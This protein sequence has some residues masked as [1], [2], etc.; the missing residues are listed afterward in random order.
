[1]NKLFTKVAALTLGVAM[2]AGVGV[3][4]GSAKASEA[5]ADYVLA[6]SF[7]FE[8]AS[9]GTS[10][11][12]TATTAVTFLNTAAGSS[13]VA[14][15]SNVAKAYSAKGS[16]G[17]GVPDKV[18]KLGSGSSAGSLTFTLASTA[19]EVTKAV[20]TAYNW[21]K[22][23]VDITVNSVQRTKA[24]ATAASVDDYVFEF[25]ATREIAMSVPADRAFSITKIELYKTSGTPVTSYS[26]TDSVEHG[27]VSPSKVNEGATLT[28]TIKPDTG[29]TLPETVTVTMG[30]TAATHTYQNGVVTVQNVTG[31]VVI[32]G[33]C[34]EKQAPQPVDLPDGEYTASFPY[35]NPFP[36][37]IDV[38]DGQSAKVAALTS[39]ISAVSTYDDSHSEYVIAANQS[40]EI[41]NLTNGKI[42]KV[43]IHIYQYKN[44]NV[45]V[46]DAT[47]PVYTGDGT[48]AGNDAH[49]EVTTNALSKVKI[50]GNGGDNGSRTFKVFD[51]KVYI[52]VASAPIAVEGV[53]L[54]ADEATMAVGAT[55]N[56]TATVTPNGADN[57]AVTW[58]SNP[59]SVA[60][61]SDNGVVTAVAA[62]DA[63]VTVTT[64]D[65]GFTDTFIA[66]VVEVNYGSESSPLTVEEAR[67]TLDVSGAATSLQKLWV[68]GEVYSSSYNSQYQDYT[69]WLKS[70]DGSENEY[71]EIYSG[72]VT[73]AITEDD[74]QANA[75]AG[76]T[77]ICNG[78]GKIHNSSVY[79][80]FK[81][82]NE[83]PTIAKYE[84]PQPVT[85]E[86][87]FYEG[88][89][90]GGSQYAEGAK[91]TIPQPTESLIPE[92]KEF[93]YWE[94]KE[95]GD[96]YAPGDEF[97]VGTSSARFDAVY[98]DAAPVAYWSD[99][100][101][102]A[103]QSSLHGVVP[104]YADS[105]SGLEYVSD[106]DDFELD[107]SDLETASA[108]LATLCNG[109]SFDG[110]GADIEYYIQTQDQL[111]Y[112]VGYLYQ[113]GDTYSP[114][115]QFDQTA[116]EQEMQAAFAAKMHNNIPPFLHKTYAQFTY[117][118]A[119]SM[120]CSNSLLSNKGLTM[121]QTKLTN[122]GF[123][124][125][126][127]AATGTR[128]VVVAQGGISG[129]VYQYGAN[130][131]D[132]GIVVVELFVMDEY[133]AM[134]A[135]VYYSAQPVSIALSGEYKTVFEYGEEF[136][137]TGIIVTATMSDE[138]ELDVTQ[139][140]SFAG[141]DAS[142]SGQ[143]TITVTVGNAETSYVVTVNEPA[144]VYDADAF[145]KELLE[146]VAPIC[147]N[148]DGKKNNR[149]ALKEVWTEMAV[150]YGTL[151][152]E[153]KAKVVAAAAKADGTD[154]EKA[155]AFYNFA[156]K[157]YGLTKF[158]AGRQVKAIVNEPVQSNSILPIIVIVA[159][160]V[161]AVTAIGVV[162]ALK[163]R[164]SLLTK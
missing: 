97:T 94:H 69:L 138:T 87:S 81:S 46:D 77:V 13:V 126:S 33:S 56:L 27:S 3:A 48:N 141:Y 80:L 76:I 139:Y 130:C 10:S 34:P 66:H 51:V 160:S 104:T 43:D 153:E 52:V 147:A 42:S 133:S 111:G 19:D 26:V 127:E 15:A 4:V 134:S 82:N 6:Y 124:L 116:Y 29:Y 149:N 50:T 152:E 31:D 38:V 150:K 112:A 120:F 41:N 142:V 2:A 88:N 114:T 24:S 123:A 39:S 86:V 20:L 37:E 75:L 89:T 125:M 74:T 53:S 100:L 59:T 64:V 68:Y 161:A 144:P 8:T 9:T 131:K 99:E 30:G 16:G 113:S 164:K 7:D 65:G 122:L 135:N 85:Y 21:P 23:A 137:S 90:G 5:K 155:M 109:W 145:A 91:V 148:Y 102:A 129:T 107:S 106:Y 96:H 163:R 45:Y 17:S 105:V 14:S 71:F 22:K 78:Y 143:Q 119:A 156:C 54:N 103:F 146:K 18:L 79:E 92:G 36:T 108:Q 115:L 117:V 49:I 58:S 151:S 83:K 154:L 44:F 159:S 128:Y 57:P 55:Y 95:T 70:S 98:K 158:I 60:T 93:D 28:A 101:L 121:L 73:A 1:M 32:S 140:A 157:K 47:D 136:D 62:G 11:E 84:A 132:G 118:D 63:V 25:A 110:E 40:I 35:A 12:L 61:V 72:S 67:A 162:I